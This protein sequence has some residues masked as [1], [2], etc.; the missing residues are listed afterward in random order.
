MLT[1]KPPCAVE[2]NRGSASNEWQLNRALNPAQLEFY[3]D[4]R[5]KPEVHIYTWKSN[6]FGKV[7]LGSF[8]CGLYFSCVYL[9]R[10]KNCLGAFQS[11]HVSNICESR[12]FFMRSSHQ[13]LETCAYVQTWTIF[14][15][16]C[17]EQPRSCAKTKILYSANSKYYKIVI[18]GISKACIHFTILNSNFNHHDVPSSTCISLA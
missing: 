9:R 1:R 14:S 7:Q 15:L 12:R 10:Y 3:D 18:F 17:A 13:M 16:C 5:E 4:T 8:C 6:S 2:L 11:A